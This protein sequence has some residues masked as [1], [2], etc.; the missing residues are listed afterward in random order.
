MEIVQIDEAGR[1][2]LAPAIDDWNP[3][4]DQGISFVIDLEGDLDLGIPTIPNHMLYVY[5]PICDEDLPD[6][7]RL[8]AIA[9]MGASLAESGYK[10]LAHC[11]MG[12]N[13]SAL[14][15][16]LILIYLGMDGKEAVTLLRKKRP[17]ALFNENFSAYLETLPFPLT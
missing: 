13:R 4:E 9:K 16:G 17:G 5:F 1:L 3:I 10:V 7:R 14:M 6:L 2:F 15:A 11:G 12:L 8:H